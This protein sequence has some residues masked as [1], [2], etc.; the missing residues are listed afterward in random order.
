MRPRHAWLL[1]LATAC[2]VP[3][4]PAPAPPL[5]ARDPA[6]A[7]E[8]LAAMCADHDPTGTPLR[9]RIVDALRECNQSLTHCHTDTHYFIANCGDAPVR[10]TKFYRQQGHHGTTVYDNFDP[11]IAPHTVFKKSIL[12]DARERLH[13]E[14]VD[15]NDRPLPV[16][17][18]FR[19]SNPA[20]LT[21]MAACRACDGE[22]GDERDDS[23]NCKTRDAGKECQDDDACEGGCEFDHWRVSTPAPRC[24]GP[25]CPASP[26]VGRPIGRCTDRVMPAC[27]HYI[28][29]H[30]VHPGADLVTLPDAPIPWGVVEIHCGCVV[31]GPDDEWVRASAR[32]RERTP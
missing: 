3:T 4:T 13:L 26:G 17:D 6:P 25:R 22:W 1:A 7:P 2:T 30:A 29:D 28:H 5:P 12:F 31:T 18:P 32:V 16:P 21:A 10:I 24:T 23:C 11:T 9:I 15:L 19:V 8:S 27:G 20:R 14:V